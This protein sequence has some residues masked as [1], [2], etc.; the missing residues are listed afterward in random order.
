[1][2]AI[3]PAVIAGGAA[4]AGGVISARGQSNANEQNVMLARENRAFQER[5]SSTAVNR[6]MRDLQK[7]GLNPIL[8]AKF[9]ASTPAGSLA[10]VGSVGGAA[11]E[12][13]SKGASAGTAFN[14][15][16]SQI[17]VQKA[18]AEK[19]KE[20]AESIRI[21]REG[22]ETRNLIL[23][24][25]EQVASIAAD[26]LRTARKLTGDMKPQELANAITKLINQASAALTN[27]MESGATTA[28]NIK[29]MLQDVKK[30][31]LLR[32]HRPD[33][34]ADNPKIQPPHKKRERKEKIFLN[35]ATQ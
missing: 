32:S 20:E 1:M 25:G 19:I 9:D 16:K 14:L 8:A 2:P 6:R 35:P 23:K 22:V 34:S 3:W 12:G 13:A 27:A 24:H 7:S 21:A 11:V 10:T 5:M 26:L 15:A 33:T 29:I 31:L 17:S 4:I 18:Q 28:K 30:F